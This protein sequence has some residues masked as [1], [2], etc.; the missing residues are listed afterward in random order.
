MDAMLT[1]DQIARFHADGYL[2]IENA[3]TPEETDR[4]RRAALGLLPADLTLPAHWHVHDGRIKPMR[5]PDDDCWDT[6]ELI[7]LMGNEKL[8]AVMAR[9]LGTP[10]LRAFDASVGITLRNDGLRDRVMSQRL[11]LDA[12]V[13]RD[14]DFLFTPEEVQLGGCY[15]LTDVEPDGGGIHVVPGG[16]RIVEEEVRA[17]RA[18]GE[19]GR[20]LHDHWGR[21]DHLA[22]R[23]VE[24]TGPAG[25]F[26]LLHHLMPHG[27][28]HNRRPATRVAQFMRYVRVPH[29]HGADRPQP[30]DR[31]DAAQR[32]AMTPLTRRLLGLDP[33]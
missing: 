4:Y 23:S 15:Y 22:G 24:V 25:S 1:D 9:L 12:S 2:L 29:P 20:A 18:A 10:H 17:A 19:D 5:T 11:H 28:S 13:P 30:A 27:A 26:A 14:A 21:L 16:H 31:Y 33:W 8:Y 3:L 7:A 6:P 32:A